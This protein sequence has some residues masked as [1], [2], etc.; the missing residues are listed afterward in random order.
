[1]STSKHLLFSKRPAPTRGE[2]YITQA[3]SG[4]WGWGACVKGPGQINWLLRAVEDQ[5]GRE[6]GMTQCARVL[7]E[8]L[9]V[10]LGPALAHHFHVATEVTDLA[11][12]TRVRLVQ[13]AG[14]GE[15]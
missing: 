12:D 8:E 14:G 15:A 3:Y 4:G 10:T 1:M 6:L 2:V 13:R 11:F 5:D 7:A 9:G